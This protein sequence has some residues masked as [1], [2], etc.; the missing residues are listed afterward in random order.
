[1]VNDGRA[2]TAARRT[3]LA[4]RRTTENDAFAPRATLSLA[5]EAALAPDA[6]VRTLTDAAGANA[7]R[8]LSINDPAAA[9]PL[10]A[11]RDRSAPPADALVTGRAAAGHALL[12]YVAELHVVVVNVGT[13]VNR[14]IRNG[15]HAS[16]SG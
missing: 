15:T 2:A 14:A 8:A 13:Q 4:P 5:E 9:A 6:S 3:L 16:N 7:P 1:M 10:D 12:A 11:S